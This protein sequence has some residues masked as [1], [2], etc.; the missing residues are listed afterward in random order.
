MPY[1]RVQN[2]QVTNAVLAGATTK[3][4]DVLADG[5]HLLSP[6][7]RTGRVPCSRRQTP[8]ARTAAMRLHRG[9][10]HS[11]AKQSRKQERSSHSSACMH[12]HRMVVPR[13]QRHARHLRL[14]PRQL[15]QAHDEHVLQLRLAVKATEQ[16]GAGHTV[17]K[18]HGVTTDELHAQR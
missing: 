16:D 1:L 8:C 13:Q 17:D 10:G 9:M 2:S 5:S 14:T 3:D 6:Q 18:N 7:A 12:T 15:P 4:D 11:T